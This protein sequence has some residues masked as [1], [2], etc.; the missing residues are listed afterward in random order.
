MCQLHNDTINVLMF[1]WT[2]VSQIQ[3][4]NIDIELSGRPFKN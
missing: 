2:N 4:L 3:Y 1:T